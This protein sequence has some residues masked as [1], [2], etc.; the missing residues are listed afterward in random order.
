[1]P[2]VNTRI[3]V[4]IRYLSRFTRQLLP[5][6][7][8]RP[9]RHQLR[10]NR[11]GGVTIELRVPDRRRFPAGRMVRAFDTRPLSFSLHTQLKEQVLSPSRPQRFTGNG[12]NLRN[13]FVA[14]R[15]QLIVS[16]GIRQDQVVGFAVILS[17]LLL[18]HTQHG[19]QNGRSNIHPHL[20]HR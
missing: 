1:M 13:F 7:S 19:Q 20:L 12:W 17:S 6:A 15:H 10:V 4:T 11:Q 5:H 3:R 18:D 8:H 14:K 2:I 9:T 16:M